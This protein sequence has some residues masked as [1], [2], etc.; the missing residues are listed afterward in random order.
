[1][2][3]QLPE[4]LFDVQPAKRL[5]VGG[6]A[7]TRGGSRVRLVSGLWAPRRDG[8]RVKAYRCRLVPPGTRDSRSGAL[9]II[10]AAL[11]TPLS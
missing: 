8:T 11:L 2:A 10:P 9:V 5:H 7:T 4:P 3:D 1:M 6:Y